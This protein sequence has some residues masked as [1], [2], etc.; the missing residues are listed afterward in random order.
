MYIPMLMIKLMF[1]Q[2]RLYISVTIMILMKL[3]APSDMVIH[4]GGQVEQQTV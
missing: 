1:S 3:S 2:E 4:N